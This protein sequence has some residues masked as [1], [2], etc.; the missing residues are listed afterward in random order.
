MAKSKSTSQPEMPK[1]ELKSPAAPS[2]EEMA[3]I[4]AQKQAELAKKAKELF[5]SIKG[6]AEKFKNEALK[7][8]KKEIQGIV[9]LPPK[10]N[11]PLDM[12][13]LL[14]IEGK[15]EDKKIKDEI[16]KKLKEIG[17]KYLENTTVSTITLDDIWDM[18]YKGKYEILSLLAMALPIYDNGWVGALRLAEIHKSMV[19]KKFEKYVVTYVLAGSLVKGRATAESDVDTFVV[20]D[21]TDVTRMTVPE[22][23]A[24]LRSMIWGMSEEAAM[25]A[26]VKNK[27]NVQ[28]Y[29]LT[30]MWD[31]IRNANA[32]IFTFLR[33]GVPLYD[34]GMF[35]PWKLLLK[36]GKI[37]PTPEAVESYIKS[38]KQIL[39]RTKF[40]LKEIALEDFFW[41]CLTPSQGA[42]MMVGVPPPDPKETP[43]QL[44]EHFVK[45]NLLEEKWVKI[46]EEILQ[47][48]KDLEHGKI[49]DVT[50]KQVE[51]TFE[52]AE[53]Y[54]ERLDKL[55]KD[56]E[57][58]QS[59]HELQE[60]YDKT[61]DDVLAALGMIG[62][63]ATVDEAFKQFEKAIVAKK[64]APTKFLEVLERIA[65]L[66]KEGKADLRELA[67]L[68]FDE[69]RL[70]KA[71]FDL[72]RAE[73]GK[74]V[75]KFKISATYNGG[76]KKADIWLLSNVAYVIKDTTDPKTQISKF[77]IEKDGSLKNEQPATLKEIDANLEKFAGT[78]TP[79]SRQ[80]IES[81]KKLLAED[82]VIVIGA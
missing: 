79:I 48:R 70:A 75:E 49:K 4:E 14:S 54:L 33:D 45:S 25:V 22:L 12:L 2:P 77:S 21:D 5:E 35:Q 42:L 15:F 58:K 52:K 13:V 60:L 53:R 64:L 26:G 69:D 19:L 9:V 36:K 74:K 82:I 47:L 24:R 31:A 37:I 27:L 72:I 38:G 57:I 8:F 28:V 1:Y 50:A 78:P 17:A 51:E 76:K 3:K 40:K 81:L 34:R 32:V 73:K 55:T 41:A 80:T 62:V 7:Q 56:L 67:T 30:E 65:E 23:V 10:K 44:R 66:K 46:L 29:I 16:E 68:T 39:D 61:V 43:A 59:R 71:T 11:A 63:K 18:C 6:K 20:I